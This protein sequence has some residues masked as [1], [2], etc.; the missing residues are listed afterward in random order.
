[1]TRSIFTGCSFSLS[2]HAAVAD[3]IAKRQ[4][5]WPNIE[6]AINYPNTPEMMG[7]VEE[8]RAG[9]TYFMWR[10]ESDVVVDRF[11]G[12]DLVIYKSIGDALNALSEWSRD[13]VAG[14]RSKLPGGT[15]PP[16]GRL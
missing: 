8:G 9:P 1:M 3:W 13:L 16:A 5:G 7:I 4:P 2:E 15:G 11:S 6:L 10:T 12:G 14:V